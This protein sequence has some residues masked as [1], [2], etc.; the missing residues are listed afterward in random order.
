MG[1][2]ELF[3]SSND[4]V[5]KKIIEEINLPTFPLRNSVFHDLMACVIEQQIPY[6]STK[7]TFNKLLDKAGIPELTPDNFGILEKYALH[8]AKLSENKVATIER[9]LDRWHSMPTDW[10]SLSDEEVRNSLRQIKGIGPWTIDMILLYTLKRPDIFPADDYHLKQLMPR[11]YGLDTKSRLKSQMKV[12]A[13]NWSPH[14]SIAVRYL[15]EWK[16]VGL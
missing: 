16:K 11:L 14:R 15:L 7:R 10:N 5:L 8:D 2:E 3:L 4:R 6:R 9:I 13:E 12:V 1:K